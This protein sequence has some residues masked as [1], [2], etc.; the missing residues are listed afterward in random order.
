MDLRMSTQ[1]ELS[2]RMNQ[3]LTAARL[4]RY[5]AYAVEFQG[6]IVTA[7]GYVRNPEATEIVPLAILLSNEDWVDIPQ[8]S[9]THKP[10]KGSDDEVRRDRKNWPSSN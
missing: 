1:V 10:T 9:Q 5:V 4:R 7:V 3:I 8:L 2:D 6:Q